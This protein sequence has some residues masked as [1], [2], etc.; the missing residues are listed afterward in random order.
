VDAVT[1]VCESLRLPEHA[2]NGMVV[3]GKVDSHLLSPNAVEMRMESEVSNAERRL[4]DSMDKS[5]LAEL[6]ELKLKDA[7]LKI[8]DALVVTVVFDPEV[9]AHAT[10]EALSQIFKVTNLV[11]VN[12]FNAWASPMVL[13]RS[14]AS[15]GVGVYTHVTM[16]GEDDG[17]AFTPDDAYPLVIAFHT[18]ESI[19][20]RIGLQ[21][22]WSEYRNANTSKQRNAAMMHAQRLSSA[23]TVPHG[24]RSV[25]G[26]KWLSAI[27]E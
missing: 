15:G 13:E 9:Y 20:A 25:R 24:A 26:P 12:T 2:H 8:E 11:E 19:T 17:V 16:E 27:E 23:V 18:P 6:S 21:A 14:G 3:A 4:M 7:A 10:E 1:K 5:E 22:A